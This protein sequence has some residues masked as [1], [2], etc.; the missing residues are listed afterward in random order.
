MYRSIRLKFNDVA[1]WAFVFSIVL[2]LLWVVAIVLWDFDLLS[3]LNSD[4]VLPHPL[5]Q[6]FEWL[7]GVWAYLPSILVSIV[8]G[9]SIVWGVLF[10]PFLSNWPR[11][12]G[13]ATLAVLLAGFS[14]L[15][16]E[17]LASYGL[18]PIDV[19][20]TAVSVFVILLVWSLIRMLL[21]WIYKRVARGN[22]HAPLEILARSSA[23]L[24]VVLFGLTALVVFHLGQ[25]E[26]QLPGLFVVIAVLGISVVATNTRELKIEISSMRARIVFLSLLLLT[27]F[28]IFSGEGV[29]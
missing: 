23:V 13:M 22:P 28:L 4:V 7:A 10:F 8:V 19:I 15:L 29:L 18:R 21:G 12:F 5:I 25:Q 6:L 20:G 27:V 1:T 17:L 2:F 9:T 11:K 26:Y 16:P 24:A 3:H 14:A